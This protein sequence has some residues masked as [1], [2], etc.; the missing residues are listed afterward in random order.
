VIAAVLLPLGIY[1]LARPH[2]ARPDPTA[3]H[4]VRPEALLT[5]AFLVGVVGGIYGIGGGSLLAPLLVAFGYSLA[6]VAPAALVTTLLTSVVGVGAFALAA[7]F[8]EGDAAPDWSL[9][10][11]LGIGGL[12]GGFIGASIQ[13][14]LPERGLRILL[15]LISVGLAFRYALAAI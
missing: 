7:G 9:G 12:L 4:R 8:Y 2:P 11:A 14:R 6:R 1:L 5:S 3:R 10:T 13:H 15:G